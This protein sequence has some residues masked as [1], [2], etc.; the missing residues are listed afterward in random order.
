MW[1]QAADLSGAGRREYCGELAPM[2]LKKGRSGIFLA[3]TGYPDCKHDQA[4]DL[5]AVKKADVLE[6]KC[7][8]RARQQTT[9]WCRNLDRRRA[10]VRAAIIRPAS[11]KQKTIEVKR[12]Q[13]SE[14]DISERRSK[15]GKTFFDVRLHPES[16]LCVA[17]AKPVG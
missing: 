6:E 2:V 16:R 7:P 8:R 12:P 15:K 11:M 13:C 14:G 4:A 9:W 17:S 5:A 10:S 1:K 3:C